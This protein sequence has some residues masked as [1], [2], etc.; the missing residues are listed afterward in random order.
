M[1]K[2]LK[3]N[4]KSEMAPI[5]TTEYDKPCLYLDFQGQDVKQITGLAVGEE[6]EILVKG[7]I[8]GLSQRTRKDYES[9]KTVNTGTIDLENYKVSVV[10]DEK[11]EFTKMA[12]DEED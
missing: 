1:A 5:A 11:N 3:K 8:K 7:T 4:V 12:E 2:K 10:E 6:V 9:E